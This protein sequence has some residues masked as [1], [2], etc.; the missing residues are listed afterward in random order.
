MN[1]RKRYL[2]VALG[3]GVI[4]CDR[5]RPGQPDFTLPPIAVVDSMYARQGLTVQVQYSGNVVELR[6][7]QPVDQL[8]RG[9]SLWARVG[10]YIYLFTPAT[11][12]VFETYD[13]VAA[14]RAI[15]ETPGGQ[16][17]ARA[18]LLRTALEE[19]RWRRAN[20][21]LGTALQE[22]TERPARIEA[23]VHF[24]ESYTEYE[25]NPEWVPV[26]RTR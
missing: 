6:A 13:G 9:G 26:R 23:L 19:T 16:E 5:I 21:L 18:L 22:G 12:A 1:R 17:I 11:R 7:V 20:N 8:R 15:T 14:V 4:G 25:Y 10:P 2:L 3:C 24:G